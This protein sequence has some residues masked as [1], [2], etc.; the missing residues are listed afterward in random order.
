MNNILW[1]IL[2]I[3]SLALVFIFGFFAKKASDNDSRVA[4]ISL[5]IV[6][7][8]FYVLFGVSLLNIGSALCNYFNPEDQSAS[9]G[10]AQTIIVDGHTYE[11]IDK[12]EEPLKEI[13][14]DGVTY[15]LVEET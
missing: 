14:I 4:A 6:A 12:T 13:E 11:R 7:T 15:R 8:T 1:I 9:S 3:I 5:C 10:N 2:G